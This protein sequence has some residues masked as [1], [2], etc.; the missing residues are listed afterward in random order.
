V[1]TDV[2]YFRFDQ[3]GAPALSGTAGA[4]IS[5]LD[6][7]LVNGFNLITLD[8]LA[9]SSEVATATYSA[10]HGYEV[11]DVI[12]I[13]GATPSGLNGEWR[14][15]AVTSTT[16]T[17][18]AVGIGDGSATG[19]ITAKVASAG[20]TKAFT[21][22]NKGAY[23]S[24]AVD[25][26]GCLLRV[27]DTGVTAGADTAVVVGYE[28]MTDIDTG[29]GDFPPVAALTR[30]WVKSSTDSATERPWFLIADDRYMWLVINQSG[31]SS[32]WSYQLTY[33]FGDFIPLS[34]S[35]SYNC[36]LLCGN[37]TTTGLFYA[38]GLNNGALKYVPRPSSGIGGYETAIIFGPFDRSSSV[39]LSGTTTYPSPVT[40]GLNISYP[41]YINQT[42]TT[43][44][45]Y[46]TE[47]PLRGKTPGLYLTAEDSSS[48]VNGASGP[49]ILES[50]PGLSGIRLMPVQHGYNNSAQKTGVLIDITGPWR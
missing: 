39:Y 24:S 3:T 36:I 14:I 47:Y 30:Y 46:A 5:L 45:S 38:D 34:G 6:A 8:S 15:T 2:K 50:I 44:A 49:S 21:G 7:C 11:H 10:G 12:L 26:T 17:F 20:W 23:K 22:T 27:D 37:S 35:D 40:G 42:S 1:S 32:A 31:T 16:F 13:D 9:V 19:T 18:A 33:G 43:S 25:A 29:T 48:L 4:L 28:T 41:A